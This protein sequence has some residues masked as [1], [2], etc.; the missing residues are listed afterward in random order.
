MKKIIVGVVALLV[1]LLVTGG[2]IFGYFQGQKEIRKEREGEAPVASKSRVSESPSGAVIT[3]DEETQARIGLKVATLGAAQREPEL[4]AYGRVLDPAALSAMAADALT[5]RAAARASE[6]EVER[7][8]T[9]ASQDNAS[10]RALQAGEAAAERDR[11]TADSAEQRLMATWG[12]AIAERKD[13]EELLRALARRD[14]ALA[15][16]DLPAG[17]LIRSQVSGASVAAL[18]DETNRVP[19][20]VIGQAPT[21]DAQTQGQGFLLL[22][23][24]RDAAFAPGAAV[25]GFLTVAGSTVAG[26]AVPEEAITRFNGKAWIYVKTGAQTFARRVVS[27]AHSQDNEWLVTEG[28]KPGELVVVQGARMLLSEEQKQQIKMLD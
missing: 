2:L 21:I 17:A 27:P 12:P 13:L 3:F 20:E 23:K 9:L 15:R 25:T 10:A 22:V 19:A 11:V 16:V 7:L 26:V 5:A 28:L 8:K 4:K 1:V 14:K 24:T 18:A 6:K